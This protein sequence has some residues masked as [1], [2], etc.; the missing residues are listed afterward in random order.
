MLGRKKKSLASTRS[1]AKA[2]SFNSQSEERVSLK[3]KDNTT[4]NS[5]LQASP[6]LQLK[7][8]A[9]YARVSTEKQEKEET[10]AS[11]IEALRQATTERGYELP[12]EFVFIDEG[13]SGARL[14]RPALDKLRDLASEGAIETILIH[15]PDRLAHNYAYQVVVLEEL[16][17]FGCEVIFLNHPL[18]Q[19]PEQQ[20][21]LQ[22]Q[23]VFAEYERALITERTRGG[24][25]FAAR[26]G[27]V[28]WGGNPPYGYRCISKS[29]LMPQQILV[30][31]TEVAIVRQIYKWL[32]EEEL[33]SYAIQHRLTQLGIPTRNHNT[34]GW[35]QSTVIEIL[36]NTIYKGE[37]FYNRTCQVDAR[38]AR[39]ERGLKDLR[40]G[41]LRGQAQRPK[42]EWIP[43]P[44]P[45]IIEPESWEMAQLQLARNRERAQR[46]N[47]KHDYLL[48]SLLR[49]GCCGRRLVGTWSPVSGGRYVCSVRYPRNK[50][51]SCDGRSLSARQVEP[52]VW[53]YISELL[54]DQGLLKTRYE[55]GRGD[56]A[57]DIKDEQERERIE[58]KLKALERE[59]ERLTDAYQAGVIELE[60]LQQRRNRIREHSQALNGRVIEIQQKSI[61]KEQELRLLQGVDEF[62]ASIRQALVEP[63]FSIKQRVLQLV[64]DRIVV[65]DN[66]IVIKHIIPTTKIRLQSERHVVTALLCC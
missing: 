61:D 49:C 44:V 54:S 55:E 37:A 29:A 10:I 21:L 48:R 3:R 4:N 31:E 35:C 18:S 57:V 40:P 50:P 38:R 11:Q 52:F 7:I 12:S 1:S 36:R 23:G 5:K 9:I 26:Q 56:P 15:S 33:S 24:K 51:W 42:E 47:S 53:N 25:M 19:N 22:I 64:V 2:T 34:Q 58:R 46:N 41:N 66:R 45:A 13:Y 16:K 63:S 32:V 39:G 60:E 62:C 43:I 28:N 65:E 14:D 8:A 27:Y 30:E 59:I 17:R 6:S 20:M